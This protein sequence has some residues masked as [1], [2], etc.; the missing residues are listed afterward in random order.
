M[1]KSVNSVTLVG[2][3]GKDPELSFIPSGAAVCKFS[4]AT[5]HSYKKGDDWIK[6][7]E[8]H[9][10]VAW[11]KTAEYC[12]ASL[13]KGQPCLVQGRIK[14]REWQDKSGGKRTAT[15]IIADVVM[16]GG[17]GPKTTAPAKQMPVSDFPEITDDLIPF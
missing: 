6:E 7:A 9:N 10:I 13:K 2:H 8:W 5:E 16:G 3:L 1:P 11:G 14:T 12:G 17:E 15:E 4:L